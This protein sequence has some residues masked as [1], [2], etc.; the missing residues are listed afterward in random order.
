MKWRTALA[1]DTIVLRELREQHSP[2]YERGSRSIVLRLVVNRAAHVHAGN[3]PAVRQFERIL[4]EHAAYLRDEFGLIG[5]EIASRN[6]GV[7]SLLMP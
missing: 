5:P 4:Q 2:L 6:S 1:H 3:E 7:G